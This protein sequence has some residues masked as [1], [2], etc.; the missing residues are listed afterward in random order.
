MSE[1]SKYYNSNLYRRRR[2]LEIHFGKVLEVGGSQGGDLIARLIVSLM[3]Q[4]NISAAK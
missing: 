1:M 3:T 4:L 2:H